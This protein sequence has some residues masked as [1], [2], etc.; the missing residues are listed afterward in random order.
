MRVD[1]GLAPHNPAKMNAVVQQVPSGRSPSSLE[2]LPVAP[3]ISQKLG[4]TG[5]GV[6]G[7][8]ATGAGVCTKEGGLT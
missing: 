5:A 1:Q 3:C 6:T 8:G 4:A 2:Q 7:A